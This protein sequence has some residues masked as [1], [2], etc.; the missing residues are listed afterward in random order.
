MVA[1]TLRS[2][3]PI[4]IGKRLMPS[5]RQADGLGIDNSIYLN[6]LYAMLAYKEE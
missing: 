4:K 5:I 1:R 3:M 2:I 6:T